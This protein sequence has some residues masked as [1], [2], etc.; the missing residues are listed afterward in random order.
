MEDYLKVASRVFEGTRYKAS[1]EDVRKLAENMALLEQRGLDKL[2]KRLVDATKHTKIFE[3]IAEHNFAVML[4]S[5]NCAE[6]P[7]SYE[8]D[9]LQRPPDFKVEIGGVTYWIQMKDLS[10]LERE[11]RQDKL[12]Q[13]IKEKA[14]EIKVGKFFSCML[15][16]DFK[17]GCLPELTNFIKD[18]TA[19]AA[20]GESFVFTGKNNQKAEVK[21]WS[22]AKN[23]II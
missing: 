21:F 18:K 15:S 23:R 14:K 8:P 10:K 12:I 7:I 13:K 5:Q 1:D 22:P 2:N 16:D 20:E 19:S 3:T 9:D 4:I 6:I 17:D 11:N